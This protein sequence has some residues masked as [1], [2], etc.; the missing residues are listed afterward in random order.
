MNLINCT[1]LNFALFKTHNLSIYEIKIWKLLSTLLNGGDQ[2]LMILRSLT[3]PLTNQQPSVTD[4]L[5]Q[6]RMAFKVWMGWNRLRVSPSRTQWLQLKN[7]LC[8]N[9]FHLQFSIG[10]YFSNCNCCK[11]RSLPELTTLARRAAGNHDQEGF[12]TN[13]SWAPI[14]PFQVQHTLTVT[15]SLSPMPNL[16]FIQ[17]NIM[18]SMV[19]FK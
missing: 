1:K 12:C 15:H 5:S 13:I 16:F 6:C 10:L 11:L 17:I 7:Q 3:E 18:H 19:G 4:V 14:A 2:I 9:I 8:L